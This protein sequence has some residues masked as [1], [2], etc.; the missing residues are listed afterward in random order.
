M[1]QDIK[2]LLK[3]NQNNEQETMPKG[4]E[5]RFL[6]R[7]DNTFPEADA[8][9]SKRWYWLSIAASI[10][11]V[12]GIGYTM[13]F[14]SDKP[15]ENTVAETT[16]KELQ[17]EKTLGD[18]S[19]DLKKIEDYYLA[20]I[21]YEL[22]KVKVTSE[23]KALFDGYIVRLEALNQEYKKLSEELTKNGPNEFT[24]NALINN[25]KMRL[26]LLYRLK[27]QLETLSNNSQ[28]TI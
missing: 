24:V 18:V 12:L 27:D 23:N 20:S 19:P 26:N 2:E 17:T 14:S 22:S 25:L 15:I 21:N 3:N 6:T 10:V 13:I 16:N 4:H 7:L 5:K 9:I 28:K 11:V 1:A 8:P